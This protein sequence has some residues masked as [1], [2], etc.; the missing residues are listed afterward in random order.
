MYD[1]E[2]IEAKCLEAIETEG[3]VFFTDLV[4]F[5]EPAL[6]TLYEWELEK[7]ELL[8]KAIAK[9][10]IAAKR[11]MRRNWIKDDAAPVLQLAAYK[12]MADETELAALT[13]NKVENSGSLSINWNE[14]KTYETK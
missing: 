11:K 14:E 12:L 8:K 6:S 2:A 13:M 1:R 7:S 3:L 4:E 5:I 10:K 9:N